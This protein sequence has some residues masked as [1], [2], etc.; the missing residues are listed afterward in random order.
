MFYHPHT[1]QMM[2]VIALISRSQEQV[3]LVHIFFMNYYML[4]LLLVDHNVS[5]WCYICA[6]FEFLE[7]VLPNGV[8]ASKVA[9][10]EECQPS[11]SFVVHRGP[12]RG[13]IVNNQWF[14]H[15]LY[16]RLSFR[17]ALLT[18]GKHGFDICLPAAIWFQWLFGILV[19]QE[20]CCVSYTDIWYH[21]HN[22][23]F[24]QRMEVF[25]NQGTTSAVR[26]N[27]SSIRHQRHLYVIWSL[28]QVTC[29][30]FLLNP[31][32]TLLRLSP[33]ALIANK[34]LSRIWKMPVVTQLVL[35]FWSEFLAGLFA[36]LWTHQIIWLFDALNI[37]QVC[38]FFWSVVFHYFWWCCYQF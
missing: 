9:W 4:A 36:G 34:I 13:Q 24:S 20:A 1:Q 26:K 12:Y 27:N 7:G 31:L 32:S 22:P 29:S 21:F 35:R 37:L 25:F 6:L 16:Y 18:W 23:F 2:N 19:S 10:L 38:F 30:T 33:I 14:P 17:W 8:D 15:S 5:R 28:F 11:E 3:H